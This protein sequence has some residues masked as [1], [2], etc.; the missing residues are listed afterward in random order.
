MYQGLASFD[1]KHP[2][3]V[4][5]V[6]TLAGEIIVYDTNTGFGIAIITLD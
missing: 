4:Y 3:V 5:V 1:N 6:S 2:W